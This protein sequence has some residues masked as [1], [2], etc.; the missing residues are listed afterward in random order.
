MAFIPVPDAAKVT[1]FGHT[2]DKEW[3]VNLWFA[4]P[5]F[6]SNDMTNLADYLY[7][8]IDTSFRVPLSDNTT[9]DSLTIYDMRTEDGDKVVKS[10]G[11]AGAQTGSPAT[12]ASACVVSFYGT[13]RG[14]WNQGRNYVTGLNEADMTEDEMDSTVATTIRDSYR[15]LYNYPPT[16]W[17]WAVVS[18]YLNGSPRTNGV[19]TA[20]VSCIV[21]NLVLGTQKRR[22][23]K[24]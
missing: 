21:R 18:R 22:L 13:K 1:I 2:G 10:V 11:L 9:V 24:T 8:W 16:P 17:V 20:V 6:D 5:G 14:K 12:V 3:T 23:R 7:D 15:Y 4:M 19:W